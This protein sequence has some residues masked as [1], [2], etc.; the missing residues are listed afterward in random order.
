MGT[1][2]PLSAFETIVCRP[3]GFMETVFREKNGAPRQGSLVPDGLGRLTLTMD[4]GNEA[5]AL[6]SLDQFSHAWIVFLF[7]ANATESQVR[8][9]VRPPKLKGKTMGLFA[10]RSP[11]RP[12]PLGLTLA[13]IDRVEERTVYFSGL[14]LIEGTPVVDVK[15]YVPYDCVPD[16]RV[17]EWLSRVPTQALTR[18]DFAPTVVNQLRALLPVCRFYTD[19][20]QLC[21]AIEQVLI[22]DPRS[23]F[24]QRQHLADG[25]I[26]HFGFCIDTLNVLALFDDKAGTVL[27]TGV[28]DWSKRD[29]KYVEGV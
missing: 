6:D 22:L 4:G 3:I 18:V 19:V 1:R 15:P 24:R 8:R 27:V 12:N 11:H 17:P 23:T 25:I 21:R 5:P 10:T 26:P 2:V 13:R 9:K 14:D 28:E 29:N 7:H 20:E 16:Y